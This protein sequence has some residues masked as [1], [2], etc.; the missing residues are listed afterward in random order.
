MSALEDSEDEEP[1]AKARPA[2]RARTSLPIRRRPSAKQ[3]SA[4]KRHADSELVAC[5]LI[6]HRRPNF[7]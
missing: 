5:K 4:G 3:P 1:L 2:K 7:S 6:Y